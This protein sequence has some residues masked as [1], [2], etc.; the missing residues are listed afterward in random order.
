MQLS[1]SG[2]FDLGAATNFVI[3]PSADVA[4][5][6]LTN[7]TP[8]G[9]PETLTAEFADLVQFG[10]VRED[11]RTLY[12]DAFAD[13]DK[14][15][16]SLVGKTPPANPAPASRRAAYVGSY[17]NDY[18]GPASRR[19]EGRQAHAVAGAAAGHLSSSRIG[20]VTCSRS[21]SSQRELAARKHLQGD[22]QRR[23]ADAGVLRH[24]QDG[25]VHPMSRSPTSRGTGLHRRRS[26]RPGRRGQDQRRPDPRV[27]QCREIVRAN[28]FTRIN[29]ILGVLLLIVLATGSLING[30]FGLLII[31]NSGIG[32]IQEL[33]AKK[34]LDKL[35]IVGQ[36]KPAVRRQSGTNRDCR[37]TRSC[38]T[39]SSSWGRATRSSSTGSCSRPPTWRSTSRC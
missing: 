17:A 27:A 34:T 2:A 37:P 30:L 13:M 15:V 9:I 31:A 21:A 20:T 35:A 32:I 28:V 39:T 19:R 14:P 5:V 22:V 12:A 18:W 23:Q 3:I 10:E 11:W 8:S 25:H 26:R 38:S 36:A 24:R 33:R 7:A 29:A 16:G 1:H 4:I 6:A